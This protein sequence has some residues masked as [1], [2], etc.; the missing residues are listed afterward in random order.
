MYIITK[1]NVSENLIYDTMLPLMI[2][3]CYYTVY[4]MFYQFFVHLNHRYI[5]NKPGVT[6]NTMFYQNYQLSLDK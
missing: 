4:S 2:L 5:T 6:D 1:L 3:A